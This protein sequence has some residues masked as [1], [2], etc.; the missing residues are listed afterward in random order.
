MIVHRGRFQFA[1]NK[2]AQFL[3]KRITASPL[4]ADRL[5]GNSAANRHYYGPQNIV[6][7]YEV[8]N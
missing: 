6:S 3:A 8:F 2:M 5:L 7:D 1:I 4:Q